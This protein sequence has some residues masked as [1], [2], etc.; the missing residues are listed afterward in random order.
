M[1]NII[2]GL[3]PFSAKKVDNKIIYVLKILLSAAILY[4]GSLIIAEV[5]IIGGSYLF[6]YNATDK[7]LP[8]DIM[9]LCC[10]YGYLITII[11]F[12]LFS[13]KVNN[14]KL[15]QIGI[16]KNFTSFF[17]GIFSGGTT[18]LFIITILFMFGAIKFNGINND[19]NWLF[20]LLYLFGY[21]IQSAMEE[22]VCR[23]YI[24]HRLKEKIPTVFAMF[25]SI[26][27]FSVGHFSKLFDAGIIIGIIGILNLFLISMILLTTTLKDKNIYSAIGFHFIWNFAL[28]NIIGLNLS[29]LEPTNSIFK[30]TSINSFLTGDIYGI[31]SS[32]ITT[33]ILMIVLLIT[34]RKSEAK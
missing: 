2:T 28:F 20:L 27:F 16:N 30:I 22:V 33:I 25:T 4:Y 17:K 3:N 11:L 15:N 24:F 23:G 26:L 7:Q 34:K 12:V 9:L 10:Y 1:R 14:I 32:I 19:V 6:G 13:K 21:L 18:L 31:E 5:L 29:G 8:Y